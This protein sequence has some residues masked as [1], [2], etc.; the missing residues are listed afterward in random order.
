MTLKNQKKIYK[1]LQTIM[2]QK[3]DQILKQK[4]KKLYPYE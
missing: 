3:I 2:F 1:N 4:E